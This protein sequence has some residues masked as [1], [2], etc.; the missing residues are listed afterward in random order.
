MIG[1]LVLLLVGGEVIVRGASSLGRRLGLTP[2]VVGL[3]VVAFG[4]SAPE[5]AVSI[6]AIRRGSADL[7]VGNVV[8]SNIANILLVLGVAA[9]IGG[10]VVAS[11]VV[12]ADIPVM[13]AASLLFVLLG[14]DGELNLI[15]G[16]ILLAALVIIVT[17][18]VRASRAETAG[19]EPDDLVLSLPMAL[20]GVALGVAILVIAARMVVSGA[21]DVAADLGVPDLVIGLTVVAL[22]TS[23]PEVATTAVAVLRGERDLA[24]GNAVGSNIFNVLMVLGASA[25]IADDGVAV[26]SDALRVDVPIMIATAVACLPIMARG[27]DLRRW[28]GGV[29]LFFYA[30][31]LTFLV[32]DA[33][34]NSFTS[35]FAV[36]T[37]GI[38]APLTAIT[39][40]SLWWRQIRGQRAVSV[41]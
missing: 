21:S 20:S 13:I 29:F 10:L 36:F 16:L 19:M 30:A 32:L 24:V 22:G 11:R 25:V 8:G 33:T 40:A 1:G 37:L 34:D 14:A 41:G 7:A 15:D 12:R 28:E 27:H 9:M 6:L 31:Y 2:L 4:T 17:W 18:T 3:T 23:A 35:R 26:S 39:V 38:A 5:L